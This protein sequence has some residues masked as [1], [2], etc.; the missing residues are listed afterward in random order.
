M[1]V[2][3]LKRG[4]A[5][6][7]EVKLTHFVAF[8]GSGSTDHC[9]ALPASR[10]NA[11]R[12]NRNCG[13]GMA[14]SPGQQVDPAGEPA[15]GRAGVTC[16]AIHTSDAPPVR[17]PWSRSFTQISSRSA[18][19]W[20]DTWDSPEGTFVRHEAAIALSQRTTAET[21]SDQHNARPT[22]KHA[23]AD[24]GL[25][26]RGHVLLSRPWTAHREGTHFIP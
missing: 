14:A 24:V 25:Q 3:C 8:G 19:S 15:V 13:C 1:V 20:A 16:P 18:V 23:Q 9:V 11:A 17:P 4:R 26:C 12:C 6:W 2:D 5:R 10:N 7:F 22:G 21:R